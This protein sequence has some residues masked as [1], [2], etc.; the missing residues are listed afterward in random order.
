VTGV[1]LSSGFARAPA[2]GGAPA[3]GGLPARGCAWEASGSAQISAAKIW[4]ALRDCHEGPHVQRG[5]ERRAFPIGA[6]RGMVIPLVH[7]LHETNH[8]G[9]AAPNG[10]PHPEEPC[11]ARRLEGLNAA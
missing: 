9:R 8:I 10:R 11:E 5:K 6:I 3:A 2:G 1:I 4:K 7:G